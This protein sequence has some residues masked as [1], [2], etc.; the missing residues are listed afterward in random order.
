MLWGENIGKWKGRQPP[1]VKPRIPLAWTTSALPPSHP[2]CAMEAFSTT[3]AVHTK[4]CEGWWSSRCRGWVAEHWRL[5]P[6]VSWVWLPAAAGLFT[7]LSFRITTSKFIYF[8]LETRCFEQAHCCSCFVAWAWVLSTWR[9]MLSL[10]LITI[11]PDRCNTTARI[12][13][14]VWI[15]P[16]STTWNR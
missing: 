2:M 6:D 9:L 5:K 8:Q 3:C 4:N 7:F 15:K 13:L 12:L 1:G 14:P 16:T 10:S 11:S